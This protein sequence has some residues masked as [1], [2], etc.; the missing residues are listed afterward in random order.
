ME[1]NSPNVIAALD[2]IAEKIGKNLDGLDK[3]ASS[4]GG[5]FHIPEAAYSDPSREEV[6]IRYTVGTGEFS[7]DKKYNVLRMKMYKMNGDHD[8]VWEPQHVNLTT[9]EG[10]K[11]AV[12]LLMSRPKP[13]QGPLD[14]PAGPIEH[15]PIRAYTKAIWG[16]G[17]G[18]SITAVGPANL[19]LVSF[20]DESSIFLVSVAAI[21]TNG[22]G[23]YEGAYGVKTALGSTFVPKGVNLFD[24]PGGKFGAVTVETFRVIRAEYVKE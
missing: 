17:D 5:Q 23:R 20:K 21:I 22:T 7:K 11:E 1:P 10:Q 3:I 6:I 16:F 19:H 15:I 4:L 13:P 8:G 12:E 14:K 9:P 2:R 18:S 24:A